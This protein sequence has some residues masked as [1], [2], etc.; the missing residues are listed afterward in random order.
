MTS[1][2]KFGFSNKSYIMKLQLNVLKKLNLI[3]LILFSLHA[4]AQELEWAK[5]IGGTENQEPLDIMLDNS[6]NVYTTGWFDG[7]V[8]FD[9]SNA[10]FNLSASGSRDIFISK[11]DSSGN[12]LWAKRFGASGFDQAYSIFVDDTGNIFLTGWFQETVDFDPGNDT[13]NLVFSGGY[14]AFVLKLDTNGDFVWAKKLGGS[15]ID[16]GYSIVA[17]E[18]GVY[19]AG[20]FQDTAD[21]DPSA[22]E[23]NLTANGLIDIFIVKLSTSGD[24]LWAKQ[25]GTTN[26]NIGEAVALD[27]VGNVYTL[28]RFKGTVDFDASIA[29]FNLTSYGGDDI[30][31]VKLDNN[32]DFI[33]AKQMGGSGTEEPAEM[34]IDDDGNIYTTGYFTGT[35]DFDP[36]TAQDF[37][38]SQGSFDVFVSKLDANGNFVWAKKIGGAGSDDG[39][40]IDVDNFGNVYLSGIFNGILDADP[41]SNVVPLTAYGDDDVYTVKLDSNGDFVWG[42][43]F[44]G[45]AKDLGRAIVVNKV[46]LDV[47]VTGTFEAVSDF[48][49]S[50]TETT[51]TSF[52]AK[53][54][55]VVKLSENSLSIADYVNSAT[56]NSY[57]NP[58]N[59]QIHVET[60]VPVIGQAQI[61]DISG[62]I[63]S[64][65]Q[66][67]TGNKA[68][69]LDVEFLPSGIYQLIITTDIL[70]FSEKILKL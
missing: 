18:N 10:V 59:H 38:I 1:Y 48:D 22:S 58:V 6:G 32:G 28:V 5:Q 21:F 63:I 52:G 7:T 44:G 34:V 37:L 23:Y 56:F 30:A 9:P 51:L 20:R 2:Y 60:D 8:D 15:S 39:K 17:N 61:I 47:Y 62:R 49:P 4:K 55:F 19:V 26:A 35:A 14:D 36:G 29:V 54:V 68:L 57:P 65:W 69:I 50:I 16:I 13:F 43:H 70:L 42:T 33:W 24:F 25:Y 64:T 31:I 3:L 27:A 12:F 66:I 53:D 46:T 45:L 11:L 41:S 40:G 67:D